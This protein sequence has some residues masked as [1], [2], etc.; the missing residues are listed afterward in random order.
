MFA[1]ILDCLWQKKKKSKQINLFPWSVARKKK[2]PQVVWHFG[3]CRRQTEK[4][5]QHV[6]KTGHSLQ[7]MLVMI[8]FF[9]SLS[10]CCTQLNPCVVA[11][12]VMFGLLT[13]FHLA[14]LGLMFDSSEEEEQVRA[15]PLEHRSVKQAWMLASSAA[16]GR[17][18]FME[19]SV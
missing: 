18:G 17:D 10:H 2:I 11:V 8:F 14:Y 7:K 1:T 12:N 15:F 4:W 13:M 3:A 5:N 16:V 9:F 6:W 19:S